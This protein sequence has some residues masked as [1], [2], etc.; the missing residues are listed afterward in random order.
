[1]AASTLAERCA[2]ER[3][4][5][6]G[7]TVG[8]QIRFDSKFDKFYFFITDSKI[9]KFHVYRIGEETALCFCTTGVMLRTIIG[10]KASL[11]NVT[12]LF[13]VRKHMIVFYSYFHLIFFFQ[14]EVHERNKLSDFLIT[15]LKFVIK[16][17]PTLKII[18]MSASMSKEKFL[19][20]FENSAVVEGNLDLCKYV[21]YHL[22]IVL[23]YP[24]AHSLY[25]NSIWRT[26]YDC[27]L[28]VNLKYPSIGTKNNSGYDIKPAVNPSHL[29]ILIQN[30]Q[31]SVLLN[32]YVTNF[33][34]RF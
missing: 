16:E 7:Q 1:M 28:C 25:K 24:V 22:L 26:Y 11:Q 8:Y 18:L 30:F 32:P 15:V 4:E 3:G 29:A 31:S 34:F 17:F 5:S 9:V 33:K 13:V 10:A 6:V 2:A 23:Q 27:K 12:H 21:I 19:N 14:D 20:Y